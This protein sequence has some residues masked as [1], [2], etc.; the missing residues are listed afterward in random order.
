MGFTEGLILIVVA[1]FLIFLGRAGGPVTRFMQVYI[2]G[3]IYVMTAMTMGVI[4]AAFMIVN[5]P[6]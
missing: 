3:Q 5:W 4:G 6:F 1:I 2:V